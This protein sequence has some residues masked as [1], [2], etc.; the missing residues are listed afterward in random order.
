MWKLQLYSSDCMYFVNKDL[1]NYPINLQNGKMLTKK[2]IL[3]RYSAILW[4]QYTLLTRCI[5]LPCFYA[6]LQVNYS[7]PFSFPSY[8]ELFSYN[9]INVLILYYTI[10]TCC[11]LKF[12][13]S[14]DDFARLVWPHYESIRTR[15]WYWIGIANEHLIDNPDCSWVVFEV[16][17]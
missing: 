4:Q 9:Y 6:L 10:L 15:W 5:L 13:D 1:H 16:I 11:F 2:S 3:E 8:H 7:N 14:V 12:Y 17:F